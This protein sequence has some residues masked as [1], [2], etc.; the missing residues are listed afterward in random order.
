MRAPT[1]A[2]PT[3]GAAPMVRN[4]TT[5]RASCPSLADVRAQ[6]ART[7]NATVSPT[8]GS[9]TARTAVIRPESVL[10]PNC[11]RGHSPI[12]L[13]TQWG[14]MNRMTLSGQPKFSLTVKSMGAVPQEQLIEQH[15]PLVQHVV[16]QVA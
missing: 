2:Q 1:A 9:T 12:G 5:S 10:C 7:A 11:L 16:I 14:E 8:I 3:V 4:P 15:L 13:P 6:A